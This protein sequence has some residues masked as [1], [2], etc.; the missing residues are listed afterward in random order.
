MLDIAE[1]HEKYSADRA[2]LTIRLAK[3]KLRAGSCA[4]LCICDV[5]EGVVDRHHFHV[6]VRLGCSEHQAS[7]TSESIDTHLLSH[8]MLMM[9]D[10]RCD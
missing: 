8:D 3:V 10:K 5:D 1:H 9:M 7:D 4:C 2:G 6:R